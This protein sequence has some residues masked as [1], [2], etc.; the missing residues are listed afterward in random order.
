MVWDLLPETTP[1]KLV[2]PE[3]VADTAALRVGAVELVYAVDGFDL[4]TAGGE[5]LIETDLDAKQAV[6]RLIGGRT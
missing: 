2:V 5:R 6:D 4:W 3:E 1:A